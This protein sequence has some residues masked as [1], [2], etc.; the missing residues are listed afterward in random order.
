MKALAGLLVIC[1]LGSVAAS[2]PE[3]DKGEAKFFVKSYSTVTWTFLSSLTST[4]P[5]TCFT[6][7]A[8]PEACPGR[9]RRRVKKLSLDTDT[10]SAYHSLTSSSGD[11]IK[12]E[13]KTSPEEKFF[14][15]LWKTSSTT[16]TITTFSTNRSITVSASVMCTYSGLVLNVC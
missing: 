13:D 2:L 14:F 3:D 1:L 9:R 4:V 7:D 11:M 6:T 10:D 8:A 16:V 15:T 5:Y 12:P